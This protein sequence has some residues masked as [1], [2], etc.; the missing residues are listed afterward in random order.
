[1]PCVSCAKSNRAVNWCLLPSGTAPL[2]FSISMSIQSTCSCPSD[3]SEL[4]SKSVHHNLQLIG[5]SLWWHA[6]LQVNPSYVNACTY[7]AEPQE[8]NVTGSHSS[9]EWPS[10]QKRA[11]TKDS[12]VGSGHSLNEDL[13]I[14][15]DLLVQ[16]YR[17]VF[18]PL[19]DQLQI[20]LQLSSKVRLGHLVAHRII[21]WRSIPHGKWKEQASKEPAL[22]LTSTALTFNQ[23]H[24]QVAWEEP[25]ICCK[26]HVHP[27]L[28][29]LNVLSVSGI[30]PCKQTGCE[31]Q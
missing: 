4:N 23:P 26:P 31:S 9:P 5:T 13:F 10:K 3:V 8:G 16:H 14:L 11:K 18:L 22:F 21:A 29:C 27:C 6:V 1:M 30:S 24:S 20:S 12:L 25:L 28:N 7:W 15:L 17:F 2:S 19:T